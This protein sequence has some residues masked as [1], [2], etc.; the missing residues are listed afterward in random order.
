MT[1][2][3]T[4]IAEFLHHSHDLTAEQM[5]AEIRRRWPRATEAEIERAADIA[6]EL[7]RDEG[8]EHIAHAD[9]LEAELRR[10]RTQGGSA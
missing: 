8:A 6:A 1:K 10:R 4:A 5:E 3:T 9:A 7:V 2:V